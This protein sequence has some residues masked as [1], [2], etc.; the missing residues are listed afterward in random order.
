MTR[1]LYS[2]EDYAEARLRIRRL[3]DAPKGTPQAGELEDLVAAI[4]DWEDS[5]RSA[6]KALL[7]GAVSSPGR[8]ST[9]C[10]P[11]QSGEQEQRRPGPSPTSPHATGPHA[12][13]EHDNFG[14]LAAYKHR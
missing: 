8:F 5:H 9:P 1:K 4:R 12:P 2:I 11:G 14:S 13:Y 3:S 7:R 6:A 10:R